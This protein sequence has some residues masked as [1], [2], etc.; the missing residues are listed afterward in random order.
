MILITIIINVIEL[1]IEH[2]RASNML[3]AVFLPV[4]YMPISEFITN[5]I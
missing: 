2:V 3:P 1:G 5:L 4:L